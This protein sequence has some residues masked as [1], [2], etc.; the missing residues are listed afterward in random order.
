MES[1]KNNANKLIYKAE[2]NPQT[3]ENKFMPTERKEK[4]DK[5][6]VWN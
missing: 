1:E 2:I 5:L 4:R 3:L 6:G